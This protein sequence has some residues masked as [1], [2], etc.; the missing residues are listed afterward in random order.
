MRLRL[1]HQQ[2]GWGQ[3]WWCPRQQH[4]VQA[5]PRP[6]PSS[7]RCPQGLSCSC[8]PLTRS[9]GG[10]PSGLR[11]ALLRC[12]HLPSCQLLPLP[13]VPLLRQ[14]GL[15]QVQGHSQVQGQAARGSLRQHRQ[16]LCKQQHQAGRSR[17]SSR[18]RG[19]RH[20]AL[21]TAT[22]RPH[23]RTLSSCPP[24]ARC[25]SSCRALGRNC[26]RLQGLAHQEQE[27]RDQ[28]QEQQH[29][30]LMVYLHRHSF[31][32]HHQMPLLQ[33]LLLCS[34][35]QAHASNQVQAAPGRGHLSG[36][37]ARRRAQLRHRRSHSRWWLW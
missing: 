16:Q 3:A 18:R 19:W 37:S 7:R 15:R 17:R 29:Q 4:R 35:K 22:A 33:P 8:C 31:S 26:Q 28:A 36:H 32:H 11:R 27:G 1:Y 12:H 34:L 21:C 30:H 24:P 23:P 6:P 10:A 9:G 2:L 13:L 5:R 25:C 20:Q 14:V